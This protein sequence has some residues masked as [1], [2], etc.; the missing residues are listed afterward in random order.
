M[1][2]A[3]TVSLLAVAG[4]ALALWQL[5]VVAVARSVPATTMSGLAAMTSREM[6]DDAKE[7][8]VRRAGLALIAAA[9][10]L[11]WRFAAALA[12]AALP[13]LLADAA[14]LVAFDRVIA[15]MLRWDYIL[16]VTLAA[17]ALS[18]LAG[19]LRAPATAGTLGPNRY[20]TADRAFHMLAFSGPAVL[21]A[22]SALEDRLIGAPAAPAAPPIF[23]TG[24]ARGGTTALLNAFHDIPG[25]A[26]HTYRDMPF[27]TA[28]TLW[29]RLAGG[30]RRG[31]ARQER[32]HGDGIEIDLD[33]PEAFEEVIWKMFW[34]EKFA[35]PTIAPWDETADRKPVAERFL[36]HHMAKVIRARGADAARYCSKNN[37]NIARLACLAQA[38]PAGRAVVP[39]RRPDCHAASLLRQHENFL[40]LQAADDFIRRYMAD[41]GHFEFGLIHKPIAFAGFDPDRYDPAGADYWLHYWVQ[42]HRAIAAEAERCLFVLQDDLRA[43][44]EATMQALCAALD[45]TPGPVPFATYFRAGPDR[46]AREAFDPALLA[47][48]DDLYRTLA[49]RSPLAGQHR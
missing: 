37:A 9:F 7:I 17:V 3:V 5:R 43:A 35:G 16:A 38:F 22:A 4:F 31:V 15:L 44:P 39:L 14:G 12:A 8:A 23:I 49:A 2:A 47:E 30:R 41:I 34:P 42:A 11:S 32:A 33:A 27:L 28:P 40:K 21:R 45:V 6:D 26:T 25:I 10:G 29:N 24:L 18:A 1:I 20:S 19:R 36:A 48:A 13:I 46:A